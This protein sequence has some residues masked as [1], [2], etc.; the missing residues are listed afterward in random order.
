[1]PERWALR[2]QGSRWSSWRS[3]T[4]APR[5]LT[6]PR[7]SRSR[8]PGPPRL[9]PGALPPAAEVLPRASWDGAAARAPQWQRGA[10]GAGWPGERWRQRG[11]G[12]EPPALTCSAAAALS[13]LLVTEFSA[14]QPLLSES[15]HPHTEAWGCP[16]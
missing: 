1:M 9:G 14:L 13:P 4:G 15:V 2:Q 3:Q 7:P 11:A 12:R 16:A 5:P 6:P 10:L 8:G